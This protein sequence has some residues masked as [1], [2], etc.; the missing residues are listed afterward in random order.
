M[1]P[2]PQHWVVWSP[3]TSSHQTKASRLD[4]V[5]YSHIIALSRRDVFAIQCCTCWCLGSCIWWPAWGACQLCCILCTRATWRQEST[6]RWIILSKFLSIELIIT[7]KEYV[8]PRTFATAVKI[9]FFFSQNF[10]KF[11]Q[12][13]FFFFRLDNSRC[14]LNFLQSG[15][16]PWAGC[17][18]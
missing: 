10:A 1:N 5:F 13:F 6:P 2:N 4:P 3:E 8:F 11:I 9:F 12:K 15:E 16:R 18:G 14:I 17:T 7:G